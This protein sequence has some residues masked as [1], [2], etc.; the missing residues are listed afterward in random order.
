[1]S[2]LFKVSLEVTP[3]PIRLLAITYPKSLL[4]HGGRKTE[5][6]RKKEVAIMAVLAYQ[7]PVM[8]NFFLWTV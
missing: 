2:K 6:E 3:L 4:T 7:D 5:R 8:S 1:M